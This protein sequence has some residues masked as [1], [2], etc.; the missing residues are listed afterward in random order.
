MHTVHNCAFYFVTWNQIS[1]NWQQLTIT[2]PGSWIVAG[3][4]HFM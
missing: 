4:C 1:Q 3:G 2:Y